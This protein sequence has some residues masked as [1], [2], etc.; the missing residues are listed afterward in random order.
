[1]D[2]RRAQEITSSPA[3]IDV[4]YNGQ[5][6]YIEHV[7][8]SNGKATIHPLDNPDKKESVSVDSLMEQ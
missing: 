1:M 8:Q 6:V 3:M 7:D 2:A 5:H 4:T